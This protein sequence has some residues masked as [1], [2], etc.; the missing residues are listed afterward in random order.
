MAESLALPATFKRS[1]RLR[2]GSSA[3]LTPGLATPFGNATAVSDGGDPIRKWL[4]ASDTPKQSPQKSNLAS[5]FIYRSRFTFN[6][7]HFVSDCGAK[8][9]LIFF[10]CYPRVIPL[11]FENAVSTNYPLGR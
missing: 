4:T 7:C 5:R 6:S 2:V 3:M 9:H 1:K 8:P 10:K 11:G